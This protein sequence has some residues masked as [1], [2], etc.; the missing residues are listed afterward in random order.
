MSDS[1]S[2]ESGSGYW[3]RVE[4]IFHQALDVPAEART[5]FVRE[6][7]GGDAAMEREIQGILTGYEAQDRIGALHSSKPLEGARFGA[8]EIVRKIGEGGMGA[9]Y[10]ARRHGDFEQRA[11][12][13]LM[14]GTPAAAALMAERFHQER[15]I[16]AGLEHPNIARVLDGGVTSGGQPYLAMEYVEGVRLD[17]YC[18]SRSLSIP[19]RLELFRK[20]CAAVHFAHQHLVIHRDLKPGNILVNEQGEP[21]LLDFGIAKVLDAPGD[22][23]ETMTM[24][25]SLLLTPQY[26]SPEQVQGLACTVASDVYSLGVILYEL[27]TGTGPYSATAS[28]PAE[29]IA[30]VITTEAQRP[31]V[32]APESLKARL[33]GDLDGIAM[34]ALAKKPDERYGSVEQLSE[35]VRRHLEGLPVT[36]VEGTRLYVARKFVRRHRVGVSAAALIL[37]SLIAGLA[38]T[39]WQ[40]RAADRQRALAE[41]RFSDARKLANYLLF[42][43][44]DA[45]QPLPGSLPVRADMAGQSLQYLDRLSTAKSN[46]RA[47]RLELAEGYLRLGTILVAP[48]GCGDSLV[49]AAP[50]RRSRA[51]AR[52][53]PFL[54][55]WTRRATGVSRS[56]GI[57]PAATFC[58]AR[59]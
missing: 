46:D 27:L 8:F 20:I 1:P 53:W 57:W 17:E 47:L 38:G 15:Q 51:T 52:L 5:A 44:F 41:Q 43:L 4:E 48:S 24:G 56:G 45:V 40:A 23:P 3:Q 59:R 19:L 29:M 55:P 22:T 16:L 50:A 58:W 31:S 9:V 54:N 18:E 14:S 6:R 34:K 12:I 37:L 11:A 13:K 2:P 32:T 21:K 36:A 49:W 39:F 42:P 7:C 28:T 25:A 26:A 35:D 10:L 30:A 33:R